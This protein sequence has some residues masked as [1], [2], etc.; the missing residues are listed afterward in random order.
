MTAR[1]PRQRIRAAAGEKRKGGADAERKQVE[2]WLWDSETR[3]RTLVENTR[4]WIWEMGLDGRHTYSNH[5]REI[6]LGYSPD[7]FAKLTRDERMHRKDVENFEQRLPTLITE[8]KGWQGWVLRFRHKNGGYRYLESNAYPILDA[9]GATCGF[10]GVA[11][12]VT[13]QIRLERDVISASEHER[14]RIGRDLH[15]GLGQML[16]LASWSLQDLMQNVVADGSPYEEP[17]K[18]LQAMLDNSIEETNRLAQL[19]SPGLPRG[20]GLSAALHELVSEID[21]LSS[22]NCHSQCSF[23]GEIGSVEMAAHLY[24]IA[25]ECMTNALKHSQ[26]KN[27]DLKFEQVGDLLYLE[28]LDDGVGIDAGRQNSSKGLGLRSMTYRA[29]MLNGSLE[30]TRRQSGGTRVLCTCPLQSP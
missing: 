19:L 12:D 2:E 15:D 27:I 22:I 10:R 26:A 14:N 8:K 18:K 25:Q 6:I 29:R 23:R 21:G 11:R 4:D 5:Q 9:A 20:L 16:I 28:V 3:Y 1:E 30:V 17:L 24:R 7:E 13:D